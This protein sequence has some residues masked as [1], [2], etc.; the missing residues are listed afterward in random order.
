MM[1]QI[2]FGLSVGRRNVQAGRRN[3]QIAQGKLAPVDREIEAI[4]RQISAING[5]FVGLIVVVVSLG[6]LAAIVIWSAS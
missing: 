6:I 5:F 2:L 4:D 1:P 3:V